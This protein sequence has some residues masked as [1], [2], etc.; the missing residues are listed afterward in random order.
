MKIIIV[1]NS[2]WNVINFRGDFLK[3]LLEKKHEILIIAKKDHYFDRLNS[4]NVKFIDLNLYN[5]FLFFLNF[6]KIYKLYKQIKEYNPV[7]VFS[8]SMIPNIFIGFVSLFFSKIYFVNTF[9]GL[10]NAF[11]TGKLSRLI[12]IFILKISQKNVFKFFF[13]NQIDKELFNKLNI[14]NKNNSE[15]VFGSG[16]NFKNYIIKSN[17][18]KTDKKF[19]FIGRLIITKGIKEYINCSTKILKKYPN[20]EFGIMGEFDIKH[21]QSI[22]KK[23]FSKIINDFKFKHYHTNDKKKY[24]EII[25]EYNCIVLPSY[26]E[27]L[28][29]SL[30]EACY[31]GKAIIA[32][33]APGMDE[34]SIDNYNGYRCDIKSSES[35]FKAMEKFIL[36]D[37]KNFDNFSKYSQQISKK[38]NYKLVYSKYFDLIEK[39]K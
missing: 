4:I 22:D 23:T 31:L 11:V 3:E 27:G 38:F 19:L 5:N 36:I 35:L 28:S 37:K 8:F 6:L 30:M 18:F 15:V 25:N 12:S 26:R 29:K 7:L 16:L 33:N 39:L 10:G 20:T 32:T 13:H 24:N 1:S 17:K 14:S 21:P 34:V 9:T 2:L